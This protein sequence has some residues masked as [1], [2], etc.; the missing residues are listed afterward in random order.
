VQDIME[1][2]LAKSQERGHCQQGGMGELLRTLGIAQEQ[3]GYDPESE[4]FIRSP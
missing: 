3:V 2:L 4:D 1:N